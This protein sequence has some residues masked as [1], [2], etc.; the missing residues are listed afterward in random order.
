MADTVIVQQPP[1]T[2]ENITPL[3]PGKST[4][5]FFFAKLTTILSIVAFSVGIVADV[6][7]QVSAAF[8]SL[9]WIGPVLNVVG[10]IGSVLATLGYTKSRTVLKASP[11]VK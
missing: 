2:A 4:T 3:T 8:P 1:A 5:E 11:Y 9:T 10:V 7:G 6:L